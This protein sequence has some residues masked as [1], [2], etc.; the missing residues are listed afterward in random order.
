MLTAEQIDQLF[1]FCRK[2]SVHYYDVQVELVDHLANALEDKMAAQPA[3]GFEEALKQVYKSFGYAGFGPLV[4]EKQQAAKRYNR[5]LLWKIFKEQWR[6]PKI[7]VALTIFAGL[8]TLLQWENKT[9]ARIVAVSGV[10]IMT[11]VMMVAV[12]RL[13]NLQKR[14][15]KKFLLVELAG[16]VNIVLLPVNC[17]NIINPLLKQSPDWLQSIGATG[18]L[19]MCSLLTLYMVGAIAT[20]QTIRHIR[21]VLTKT[22]PAIFTTA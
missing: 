1:A 22:Y 21:T 7:V 6:W 5:K 13:R 8:Y 16:I 3:I 10:V 11:L 4:K 12:I 17:F 9:P 2:H 14:T 20:C 18:S 15:G 19:I